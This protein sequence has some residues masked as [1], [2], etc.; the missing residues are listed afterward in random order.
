MSM[1]YI[2]PLSPSPSSFSFPSLS[3]PLSP[4]LSLLP[5]LLCLPPPPSYLFLFFTTI[6]TTHTHTCFKRWSINFQQIQIP[7][8]LGRSD[9][10]KDW[11]KV[12]LEPHSVVMNNYLGIG[13]DAAI[14]LDFHL[15][16]EENPEKFNSR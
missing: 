9:S 6:I 4:S 2:L 13:L 7:K 3:L 14:A 12:E 11:S 16:R 15:A 5:L 1:L 8:A 10:V